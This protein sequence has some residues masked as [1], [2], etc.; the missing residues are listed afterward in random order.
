MNEVVFQ[1]D[2]AAGVPVC[3]GSFDISEG[4]LAEVQAAY[5]PSAEVKLVAEDSDDDLLVFLSRV[6][7]VAD[8]VL[9]ELQEPLAALDPPVALLRE[10]QALW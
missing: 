3:T 10:P 5:F 7:V 2:F 9:D 1:A 6:R 8:A 4:D